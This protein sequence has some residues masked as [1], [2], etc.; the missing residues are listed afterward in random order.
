MSTTGNSAD[1][2]DMTRDMYQGTAGSNAI[3][4]IAG[5]GSYSPSGSL[6][7]GMSFVTIATLGNAVKFGE[8]DFSAQ[9]RFPGTASDCVRGVFAGGYGP[10]PSY[11]VQT[12]MDYVNIS[13]EGNAV[14]FGDLSAGAAQHSGCS[15][16]HGGLG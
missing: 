9:H 13:T 1:F 8:N 6:D 12:K 3:R 10:A 5:A 7:A 14:D 2:G 4:A 16:G 15:N 11:V